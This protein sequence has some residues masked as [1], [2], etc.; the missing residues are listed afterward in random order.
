MQWKGNV[1]NEIYWPK[2]EQI[3]QT[4]SLP[5]LAVTVFGFLFFLLARFNTNLTLSM[6]ENGYDSSLYLL[7]DVTLIRA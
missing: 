3:K 6:V 1:I 4:Q 5:V 7:F 2:R